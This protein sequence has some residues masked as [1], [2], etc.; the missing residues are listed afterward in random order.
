MVF[1]KTKN[2]TINAIGEHC[3][4]LMRE[5][6]NSGSRIYGAGFDDFTRDRALKFMSETIVVML[7][8]PLQ[9]TPIVASRPEGDE[10]PE[11]PPV[12]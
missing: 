7:K 3:E 9:D 8:I 4:T 10:D 11:V 5:L 2:D 12:Q 1:K 6:V